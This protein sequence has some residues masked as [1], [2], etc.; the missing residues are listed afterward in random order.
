MN[1]SGTS[2]PL[3]PR[4]NSKGAALPPIHYKR[5]ATSSSPVKKIKSTTKRVAKPCE[6][7]VR[8][9]RKTLLPKDIPNSV[10]LT[11]QAEAALAAPAN[12]NETT[13]EVRLRFNH[14]NKAFHIHN[15]VLKWSDVDAEY[16]FSFVYRGNYKRYL[17]NAQLS[18][19]GVTIEARLTQ[20]GNK[21]YATI[22]ESCQYFLGLRDGE[23]Y[24]VVVEED[25]RAGI[26]AEGLRLSSQ[27]LS[28]H[29]QTP[30]HS[31][32]RAVSLI[33]SELKGLKVSDLQS[34]HAK[35][36]RERRDVEDLVS[37][38][39]FM[40]SVISDMTSVLLQFIMVLIKS[41]S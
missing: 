33:T 8:N 29:N 40:N 34:E 11:H 36:L 4:S 20:E 30:I 14:Y 13:G 16:C 21:S 7:V 25:P 23:Q 3:L 15:S 18:A 32:N 6:A 5:H 28:T 24:L 35:D 1:L 39:C 9:G 2:K 10:T 27:P 22:D 26:G 41:L 37:L 31:G 19:N 38:P 17:V 12:P